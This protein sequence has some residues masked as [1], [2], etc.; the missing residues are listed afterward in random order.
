M[1]EG[2][3]IQ[4]TVPILDHVS[5]VTL[6]AQQQASIDLFLNLKVKTLPHFWVVTFTDSTLALLAQSVALQL[7]FS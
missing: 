4:M 3:Q 2:T 6:C 7:S 1:T 5:N